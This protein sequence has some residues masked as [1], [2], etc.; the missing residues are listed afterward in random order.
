MLFYSYIQI[1]LIRQNGYIK[2]CSIFAIFI[3]II[4]VIMFPEI[5]N[6]PNQL[7]AFKKVRNPAV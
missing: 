2:G 4:K 6:N 7:L 3:I 1:A 5:Y